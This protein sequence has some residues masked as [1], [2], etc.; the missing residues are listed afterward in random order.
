MTLRL[1]AC[2]LP[3]VLLVGCATGYHSANNPILGYTGGYWDTHGPGSTIKVG[4]SGN[5][6]ITGEKVGTY[7]LYRC[8][9]VTKREGGSHFVLYQSLVDAVAD[10]RS[11]ERTVRTIGGKPATYAYIWIV[12]GDEDGALS[13]DDILARLGPEVKPVSKGTQ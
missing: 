5:G 11:S 12:A 9:E 2:M 6:F 10:R 8:A 4:F 13:A 3:A 7:L 1:P